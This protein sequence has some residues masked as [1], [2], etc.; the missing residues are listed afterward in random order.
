MSEGP[1]LNC[2]NCGVSTVRR[3]RRANI[4]QLFRMML[5]VYPFRCM[6]CG[7]RFS[8]N[9]WL[10]SSWRYAKCPRCLNLN[11]TDWPK[12]HYHVTTWGQI[13]SALGAKKQRCN[14]CR[15]NFMSF[16]PRLLGLQ[17]N[18]VDVDDLDPDAERQA[19]ETAKTAGAKTATATASPVNSE[20]APKN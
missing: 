4:S 11:L 3:S 17:G 15:T 18:Q 2:P 19:P 6:A 13:M 20:E 12:R 1:G 7:D 5:G 16:R 14:R 8:A 9:V 10:V